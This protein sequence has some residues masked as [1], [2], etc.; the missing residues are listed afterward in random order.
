MVGSVAKPRLYI[1]VAQATHFLR[2]EI[3]EFRKFFTMVDSPSDS[4]VLLSFGPDVLEEASNLPAYKRFAVLFP[5]FSHNPLYN[6]EIRKKHRSLIEKSFDKVFINPGPLEIAYKGLN[7]IE[8]YPFSID[9]ELVKL[10]RYRTAINSLVHVSNAS[11]QKD[12]ERSV[13]IMK[14]T[15]LK[16]SVFPPR[17]AEV[18]QAHVSRHEKR[19]ALRTRFGIKEKK[20]LP[21]GYL[22]HRDAIKQYHNH[23]GFVHVARD[24]KHKTFIDGKYTAS[25]IEAGITGSI[26]FWHDTFGLGNNLETV[27]S[28]PLD[29]EA[30][31]REILEIRSSIDVRKHSIRTHEEMLSIFNPGESVKVRSEVILKLL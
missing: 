3:P 31:A 1:H 23:D 24:I 2:W 14:K 4:T 20:F 11:P 16:Q 28:L 9:T 25:L 10:K 8:F 26:L 12:W 30:A 15:G 17:S 29:I 19:N 6:L 5:G 13:E 18:Y 21:W 22:D 7:N 27:F